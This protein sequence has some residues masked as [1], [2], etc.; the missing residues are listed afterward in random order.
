MRRLLSLAIL[1][2][3]LLFFGG[4]SAGCEDGE[5]DDATPGES[6]S[7]GED[8]GDRAELE[9]PPGSVEPDEDD[10]MPEG[11]LESEAE[12]EGSS[13][14]GSGDAEEEEESPWGRP[15]SESG[16]P[17]PPRR[18]MSGSARSSYRQGLREA[19][20]GN[21]QAAMRSFQQ[22]LSS[23]SDAYKAA[24]N[25]GVLADRQGN[26]GRAMQYYQ[27]AL[28]IQADY[29]RAIEG[30]AR[31]HLR[32]NNASEAV[33]FVRPLADRWERNL[34]IQAIYGDVLVHAG[35]PEE[36]IQAARRALRRDE[37]FVPAMIV[38]VKA[39]LR[40]ERTELAESILDQAIQTNESYAELHYLRGRMHQQ[41][42][43]LAP[44]LQSYRRA[45]EIEPSYTEARMALGL[46]QLASG[47]Y[48]DALQQFRTAANLAPTLPAVRLALG[49]ALRATKQ[50]QEAKQ[51]FDRVQEMEPENA[52]V[53]FNL[54]VMY[55]EAGGDFPGMETIEAYQAGVTEF[56]RYRELMGPRLPRDD[57]SETYL[58]EL[59]RLI[60]REQRSIER[61]RARAQREAE[62]AARQEAEAAEGGGEGGDAG[63]GGGG[64]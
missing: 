28:R 61:E 41:Q 16:R 26:E 20:A 34:H 11:D 12:R 5:G 15:E 40:L 36:A 17:L 52:D 33:S 19:A 58:E 23:D 3:S 13:D 38:L 51:E 30:I 9:A 46:Q 43:N 35:R 45:I 2:G 10:E 53:H 54:G 59:G 7:G 4:L 37:R 39:N 14:G 55:R 60:E 62:R 56:N 24:Y 49:D 31:I 27:Q 63:G 1:G 47:N 57:P 48:Q 32:R 44:A 22:A 6:T 8:T 42:G 50:W 25:L 18:P 21:T 64:E 29:E